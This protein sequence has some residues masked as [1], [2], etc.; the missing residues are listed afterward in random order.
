MAKVL[1]AMSGGVDSS[2]AAYLLQQQGHELIGA[3][4][5]L[6]RISTCCRLEDAIDAKDVCMKL[7]IPHLTFDLTQ[8]FDQAV[9]SNF[10]DGYAAGAT[11][12]PCVQCNKHLKFDHLWKRAQALGCDAIATGHYAR[13]EQGQDGRFELH[14]AADSSKDQSYVLYPIQQEVLAHLMLPLGPITSKA[15]V[16]AM[17]EQAGL[18][19]AHKHDSQDI[20]FVPTGN[21]TDFLARAKGAIQEAFK[22]GP[23]VNSAGQT[24]GEHQGL[25]HYTVGQRKGIGV[26]AGHPLY[27]LAKDPATN[28]LIVGDKNELMQNSFECERVMWPSG[29]PKELLA[30]QDTHATSATAAAAAEAPAFEVE[31]ST[32]YNGRRLPATITA[33]ASDRISVRYHEPTRAPAPGQ[34]AVCY[35]GTR[36]LCGGIIH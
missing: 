33:L 24:L 21:Y 7:G 10:V 4:M 16:R 9:V 31:V 14:R 6:A 20:C 18:A 3:T 27:V 26:A 15:E 12:N 28:T 34:S 32:H 1:V 11:P 23:I 17:A 19:T 29:V 2:V 13:V 35:Q 5:M 25:V 30:A 22:P 8:E 36:V